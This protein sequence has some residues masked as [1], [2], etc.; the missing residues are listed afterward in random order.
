MK[1]PWYSRKWV[2]ITLHISAW[3]LLFALPFLLRPSYESNAAHKE[4]HNDDFNS[5]LKYI[6]NDLLW[7]SFFYLN[8]YVL[9]PRFIY[10]KKYWEYSL[11]QIAII[12]ALIA[13]DW[14]LF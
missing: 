13:S 4:Q 14:I 11:L 12:I 5:I 7:I 6:L 1:Q 2:V 9:I 10:K 3:V 8:A